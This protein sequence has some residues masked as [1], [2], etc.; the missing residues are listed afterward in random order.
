MNLFILSINLFIFYV[1]IINVCHCLPIE[2]E[3][4]STNDVEICAIC[5]HEV[6]DDFKVTTCNH[7]FC[8]SCIDQWLEGSGALTCPTCRSIIKE[9]NG[10]VCRVGQTNNHYQNNIVESLSFRGYF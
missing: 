3:E 2:I 1:G 10:K 7:K 6:N 8:K 9:N 5:L 4:S